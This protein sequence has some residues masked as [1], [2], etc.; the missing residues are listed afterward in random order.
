MIVQFIVEIGVVQH[1]VILMKALSILGIWACCIYR[2]IDRMREEG[3]LHE[4]YRQQAVVA[5][6]CC[7]W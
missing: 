3:Y 6:D 1:V 2:G 7:I 5:L 4:D